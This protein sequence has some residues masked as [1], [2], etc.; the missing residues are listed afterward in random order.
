MTGPHHATPIR[1]VLVCH[2]QRWVAAVREAVAAAGGVVETVSPDAA[3]ARLASAT[4]DVTHMLVDPA[5]ADGLAGVLSA[6]T[7]DTA[8]AGTAFL[9]LGLRHKPLPGARVIAA[10]DR[11][12]I[13]AALSAAR[14]PPPPTPPVLP[15]ADLVRLVHDG[16]IETRYQPI[17]R[18]ADGVITSAEVLARLNHPQH[19]AL[20]PNWFIPRFEETGL[21]FGLT[22]LVSTRAFDDWAFPGF[23][24][25]A[26]AVN[27]P[28]NVLS[29]PGVAAALDEQRAA[30]GLTA[31]DVVIELTESRPVE[32]FAALSRS[33]EHLRAVGYRISI[34]DAGPAVKNLDRL[35]TLPF[36]GLKLD[37][38]IVDRIGTRHPDAATAPAIIARAQKLGLNVVAEGV[39][40]Q[41]G[42]DRLRAL[43]VAEAQGFFIAR[44]LP[45]AAVPVWLAAWDAG[46]AQR[47]SRGQA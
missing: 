24:R 23:P 37:K 6:L 21:A 31:A 18:M 14:A 42:W 8:S 43:G 28:L 47:N 17:A 5:A 2:D 16:L 39:E 3:V 30:R 22:N 29:H 32:D 38:S 40:T 35:L 27:Y 34:D 15:M 11:A 10:P 4:P 12:G 33:L 1:V 41:A 46:S 44:P 36:T 20:P 7:Y 13:I 45:A 26:I 9:V 19:G 25:I